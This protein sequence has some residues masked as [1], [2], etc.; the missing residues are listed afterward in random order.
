LRR[1]RGEAH[2]LRALGHE[3]RYRS[4]EVCTPDGLRIAAQDWARP[5]SG[6]DVLLIHG[7]SQSHLSWLKQVSGPLVDEFRL[8]T[9][10]IRGH[11][12]SDKP[13][14]AQF[15]G[16][17][18]RWAGEVEA[19]IQAADLQ[20]PVL[21]FWS[22]GGR[23]ALDYL[24]RRGQQGVSGLVF[25]CATAKSGPGLAGPAAPLRAAMTQE[26]LAANI[27]ATT[28]FLRSCTARPLP[29]AEFDYVLAFNMV[30]PTAVR[31]HLLGRAADYEAMLRAVVVPALVMHGSEDAVN[32]PAVSEYIVATVPGA[33]SIVYPG[34][35]HTP[36]WESPQAFDRDLA[37]FLRALPGPRR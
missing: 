33:R 29:A 8:V 11:G 35:G 25:V 4:I 26:D 9:Y 15:Y 17:A 18:E 37:E 14:A 28:A 6:R 12:A 22:Y 30:V 10:D 20:Q 23:I 19:V 3:S 2:T 24:S 31:A 16:D 27:A 21:L 34:I 13:P 36:F 32:L 5:G 7:Y 1:L